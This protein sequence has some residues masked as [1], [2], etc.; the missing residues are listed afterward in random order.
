[1]QILWFQLRN[2]PPLQHFSAVGVCVE[3]L[4]GFNVCVQASDQFF[5][6]PVTNGEYHYEIKLCFLK[7][8]YTNTSIVKKKGFAS[9]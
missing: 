7:I 1:M 8:M 3:K 5:P 2:L 6:K 4:G 9:Q